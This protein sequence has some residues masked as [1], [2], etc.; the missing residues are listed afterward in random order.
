MVRLTTYDDL[1]PGQ[2]ASFVRTIS[3]ADVAAFRDLTGDANPLHEDEAFARRTFFGGTVAH[4]MLSGAL[5]STLVGMLLPGTGAIYLS[6]TLA[7]K[8]PV[9]PGDTLSIHG[10]V[11]ALDRAANR[12]TLATWIDNQD[13]VRVLDGEAVVS[14]LRGLA[15]E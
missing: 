14:L 15:P 4:G 9:R 13:G 5:F 7:F 1:A 11:S 3:R 2:R 8:K 6:Q 12:I 10:E